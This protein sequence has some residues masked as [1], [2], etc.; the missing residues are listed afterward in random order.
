MQKDPLASCELSS[1]HTMLL[2]PSH[3]PERIF[4][5]STKSSRRFAPCEPALQER[6]LDT[7]AAEQSAARLT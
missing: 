4:S 2:S 3:A 6:H 5:P 7:G 1:P